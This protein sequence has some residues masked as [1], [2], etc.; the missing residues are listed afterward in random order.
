MKKTI[1]FCLFLCSSIITM[2]QKKS[3]VQAWEVL[4]K[5]YLTPYE[6]ASKSEIRE[7][8]E[9]NK[10]TENLRIREVISADTY[11]SFEGIFESDNTIIQ[12][13]G[14]S[15][16][17]YT[18]NNDENFA[19]KMPYKTFLK[20][21]KIKH[22][23][24]TAIKDLNKHPKET[25]NILGLKA[26]RVS[27][28][29]YLKKYKDVD[30]GF[31]V[32]VWYTPDFPHWFNEYLSHFSGYDIP[33]LPLLT[34]IKD[35]G[36]ESHKYYFNTEVVE[37]NPISMDSVRT[38]P[39]K[40]YEIVAVESLEELKSK[41][42]LDP[43]PFEVDQNQR[44]S[45]VSVVKP[46]PQKYTGG[47]P[48]R[49]PWAKVQQEEK[50]SYIDSKGAYQ[51]DEILHEYQAVESDN[52]EVKTSNEKDKSTTLYFVHRNNKVGLVNA[53]DGTWLLPAEYD[54]IEKTRIPLSEIFVG[55]KMGYI[56]DWGRIV[57]PAHYDDA[58]ALDGNTYFAVKESEKWGVYSKEKNDIV[59][60]IQYDKL[61]YCGGCGSKPD[62]VYALLDGK[63]GIVS[64]ENKTLLPFEYE[65]PGHQGMRSGNWVTN[66]TKENRELIINIASGKEYFEADY[67]ESKL[68][69]GF[70][71]LK[72]GRK[73]ALVNS[74]GAQISDFEYEGIEGLYDR[75]YDG[76]YIVV[77]SNQKAGVIDSA[78]EILIKPDLYH[79]I[80]LRDK[81]FF[82]G[83]N[84]EKRTTGLHD[85][86]GNMLV[87]PNYEHIYTRNMEIKGGSLKGKQLFG[88]EQNNL[89]GWYFREEGKRLDHTYSRI[90]LYHT[91]D[92]LQ[93]YMLVEQKSRADTGQVVKGLKD[94]YGK[95]LIPIIYEDIEF[96]TASLFKV[97]KEGKYGLFD[98]ETSKEVL[99]P[100]YQYISKAEGSENLLK[101][102]KPRE[103]QYRVS[104]WNVEQQE[105]L[106][107]DYL[108]VLASG[109]DP[110]L[111]VNDTTGSYLYD[112]KKGQ[113]VSEAYDFILSF[114]H[115]LALTSK[116]GKYGFIDEM[117]QE[118][119]PALYDKIYT[120]AEG[121][122]LLTLQEYT[123]R[124]KTIYTT[125]EGFPLT[126]KEF[127]SEDPPLELSQHEVN[128]DGFQ[129]KEFNRR[130]G[131]DLYGLLSHL[132]EILVEPQ[133]DEVKSIANGKAFLVKNDNY[134]GLLNANGKEL[135]PLV[136]DEVYAGDIWHSWY[137]RDETPVHFPLLAR[138]GKDYFYIDQEGELLPFRL[139]EA[140]EF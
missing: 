29:A 93:S 95:E 46:Y 49:T 4:S 56:D 99:S 35:I 72:K 127:Y 102:T 130:R 9:E 119:I 17:V 2:G 1:L 44:D 68:V 96:V 69:N 92:S 77:K 45:L 14:T 51:F 86:S 48:F 63:W 22:H 70:L 74:D 40:G 12:R 3:K 104:W 89:M 36:A 124:W 42:V 85:L 91:P 81:Q 116:D 20:E 84:E 140:I 137:S 114:K 18:F 131:K 57:L 41:G 83:H 61:D 6:G 110:L 5:I 33:G 134:Y 78:G 98:T 75:F 64:F 105:P 58:I 53:E 136:L 50:M 139:G 103:E 43:Q 88:V 113:I 32:D 118:V 37:I 23:L 71:A 82:I 122:K 112:W 15:F 87:E 13:E 111:I 126:S 52:A 19:I 121:Y 59:V 7:I 8:E 123:K 38:A 125:P 108:E 34:T 120:N 138:I 76:N 11:N 54:R 39:P 115:G 100:D 65:F 66:L 117:G 60:P 21:V 109:R 94:L 26:K 135:I 25:K 31:S 24:G 80:T 79:S 107:L 62:Y 55:G 73:Y 30:P 27:Y 90:K 128:E 28:V 47:S 133:Y 10:S 101:L 16:Y 97:E 106:D 67:Q 129:I 132:G